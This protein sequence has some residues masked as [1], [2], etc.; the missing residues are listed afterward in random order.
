MTTT[1]QILREVRRILKTP[2]CEDIIEH[3]KRVMD[4]VYNCPADAHFAPCGNHLKF[5]AR[6]EWCMSKEYLWQ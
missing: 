3:A 5:E 4:E 6:C 2:E 1:A